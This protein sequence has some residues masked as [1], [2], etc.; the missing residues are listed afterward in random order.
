MKTTLLIAALVGA[1]L[2]PAAAQDDAPAPTMESLSRSVQ[3]LVKRVGELENKT[4]DLE[5][6]V[7]QLESAGPALRQ[8]RD[9]EG[10]DRRVHQRVVE[11]GAGPRGPQES[12][13]FV[14]EA[15]K[16][17]Q[18]P[19]VLAESLKGAAAPVWML[20]WDG[21]RDI[22]VLSFGPAKQYEMMVGRSMQCSGVLIE[23]AGDDAK[24]DFKT[25][26]A[27][28][29]MVM[30]SPPKDLAERTRDPI[31]DQTE[32]PRFPPDFDWR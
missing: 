7:K 19:Q 27:T 16:P 1:V 23:S 21:Q 6:R 12:A 9:G 3:F 22:M 13:V 29:L 30:P 26:F 24:I 14:L 32:Y 4:R 8:A 5:R 31:W 28:K 10:A 15:V 11:L 25:L 20:G 17:A 18:L 2:V